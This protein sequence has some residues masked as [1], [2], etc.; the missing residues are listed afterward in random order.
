MTKETHTQPTV[1]VSCKGAGKLVDPRTVQRR[2]ERLITA[3]ELSS[4]E[5]SIVLSDDLFIRD[6][7]RQY[8]DMDKPTD[9][10]SFPMNENGIAFPSGMLGDVVISV[11]TA[12]RQANERGCKP[13]DE[14]TALLIHGILH[15]TGHDHHTPEEQD[16]MNAET[17][18]LERS[19]KISK[20]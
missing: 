3:L 13:I 14:V 7:N 15:L 19:L 6:L 2:A 9:V 17:A 10:L 11:E 12:A 16:R 5:L 1:Q 20:L 4:T 8:R 18:R